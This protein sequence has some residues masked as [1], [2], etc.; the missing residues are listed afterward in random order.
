[1]AQCLLEMNSAICVQILDQAICI[2][3]YVNTYGK[4]MNSS[5]FPPAMGNP[6]YQ[7]L[8]SGRI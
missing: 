4:G 3:H 2:P 8:H 5:T 7:P 1:M 6:I